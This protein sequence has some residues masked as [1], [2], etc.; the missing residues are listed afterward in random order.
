MKK[1]ILLFAILAM[2]VACEKEEL[3]ECSIS[4]EYET[5]IVDGQEID[6]PVPVTT[7]HY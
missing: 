6:I 1:L 4:Y 3:I 7:C 2:G 5:V